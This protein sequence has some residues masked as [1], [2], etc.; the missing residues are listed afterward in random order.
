MKP[1]EL[2]AVITALS[3]VLS[4]ALPPSELALLACILVQL[5]DTLATIAAGEAVFEERNEKLADFSKQTT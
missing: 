1:L 3:N 4:G 2:T 5:G